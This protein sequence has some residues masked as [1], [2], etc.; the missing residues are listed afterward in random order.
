MVD[1]FS[2][3]L[4]LGEIHSRKAIRHFVTQALLFAR[5]NHFVILQKTLKF[6]DLRELTFHSVACSSCRIGDLFGGH[7]HLY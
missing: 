4:D 5:Q 3:G 1:T 6:I 2:S 7:P